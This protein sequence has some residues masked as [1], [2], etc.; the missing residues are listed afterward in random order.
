[1]A[2]IP[3]KLFFKIGEVAD[4]LDLKTHV[5]RYWETEFNCLKPVKSRS[6]QRLYRRQDVETA[7]L[8][9]DL[10]YQQ[11][12]TIAGARNQ[13]ENQSIADLPVSSREET[14]HTAQQRLVQI[15]SDLLALRQS[16][17]EN[18]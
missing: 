12:F 13:L 8:I 4:L 11:G 10:L 15:K 6:N 17:L 14:S 1:V 9:K 3:D 7:L 18:Q 2:E 5:L 16:L